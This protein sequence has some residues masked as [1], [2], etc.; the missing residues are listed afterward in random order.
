MGD[1]CRVLDVG[2]GFG[3]TLDHIRCRNRDC[4]L[5]GLNIDLRQLQWARR[6]VGGNDRGHDPI[7]LVTGDGC[8]LP[9]AARQP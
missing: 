9:V 6:V 4:R 1:G 5:V 2:C 8:S 3:G 7:S